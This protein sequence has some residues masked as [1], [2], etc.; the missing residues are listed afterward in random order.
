MSKIP[1][2]T[3]VRDVVHHRHAL[4]PDALEVCG[5]L[6]WTSHVAL[7][8]LEPRAAEGSGQRRALENRPRCREEHPDVTAGDT[9]ESL[10]ALP[11]DLGVR[12]G[13]PKALARWIERDRRSSR[14][15]WRSANQRS[16]CGTPSV[17]ITKN[18]VGRRRASAASAT[19]SLEPA[20][21]R[22]LGARPAPATC[23]VRA[24]TPGAPR[25]R[26]SGSGAPPGRPPFPTRDRR[27]PPF[28][29]K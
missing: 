6:L 18:R 28:P 15:A 19:A 14:M 5:D 1:P 10:D 20:S 22:S 9:L 13:L 2:R 21:R 12:L 26:R 3:L 7:S 23:S 11:G 24:R 17:T 29:A 8:Q 4:E 25:R 16:A 27:A